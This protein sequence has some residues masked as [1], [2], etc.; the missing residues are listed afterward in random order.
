MF[1]LSDLFI[2]G[3]TY[4]FMTAFENTLH[5]ASHYKITGPLY[6]WHKLHHKDYPPS[7]VESEVYI[8][9]SGFHNYFA[10]IIFL[11]WFLIY[12]VSSSRTFI[13][14][15]TESSIY[16]YCVNYFHKQFHLKNSKF[17]KYKLFQKYKKNHL[18]HHTK[19]NKNYNFYD[20]TF[21]KLGNTYLSDN[22]RFKIVTSNS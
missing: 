12:L 15:I 17:N 5:K 11:A 16:T 13:I 3:F 6:K 19:L 2:I 18:V 1:Y 21:D 4:F 20:P 8:N 22:S 10:Y 14:F 7:K 9:T